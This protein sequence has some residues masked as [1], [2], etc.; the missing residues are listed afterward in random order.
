MPR[1]V[2]LASVAAPSVLAETRATSR[3]R[4]PPVTFCA[5]LPAPAWQAGGVGRATSDG[6]LSPRP[7]CV[8]AS[9]PVQP[10]EPRLRVTQP[11]GKQRGTVAGGRAPWGSLPTCGRGRTDSSQLA[12]RL[13]ESGAQPL[14]RP[15]VPSPAGRRGRPEPRHSVR[16]LGRAGRWPGRRWS[17][18]AA[19]D[20]PQ[21]DEGASP[22]PRAQPPPAVSLH[23]RLRLW[24][25]VDVTEGGSRLPGNPKHI[26]HRPA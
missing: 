23:P 17:G 7:L 18:G 1:G 19:V 5:R 8:C 16:T 22:G 13:D 2:P 6:R 25:R 14:P 24:S 12:L 15:P 26:P 21:G 3:P 20:L 10:R 11:C 9:R 4:P